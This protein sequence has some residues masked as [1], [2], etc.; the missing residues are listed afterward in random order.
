M[1]LSCA[2]SHPNILYGV[3][4]FCGLREIRRGI[5]AELQ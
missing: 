3:L 5:H 1:H 4:S 2:I